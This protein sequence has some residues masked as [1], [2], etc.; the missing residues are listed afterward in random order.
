MPDSANCPCFS[1]LDVPERQGY[2]SSPLFEARKLTVSYEGA[3]FVT[4]PSAKVEEAD[5]SLDAGDIC[6]LVGPSGSGKSMLFR[7][8]ALMMERQGGELFLDGRPDA[9]FSP[10]QWRRRVCLVPQQA[11]LVPGSIRDNLLVPWKLKVNEDRTPPSDGEL[12]AM[13]EAALLDVGLD[14]NASKLSGGQAARVALVRS[15]AT[16]PKVLLLDEVD[17]ALDDAAS[18]AVG[19][20]ICR[21]VE[22]GAACIRIRHRPPD[23]LASK[24]LKLENGK[25]RRDEAGR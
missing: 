24:V 9:G 3:P 13:L 21:V 6:D 5:I 2:M 20:L 7:A 23:G 4:R 12:E 1:H 22:E 19:T 11:A 18:R 14:R 16:R 15:L 25:V 10:T 17:S 8:M